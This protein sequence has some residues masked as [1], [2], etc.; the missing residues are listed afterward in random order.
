MLYFP[1]G[2]A[3]A[4]RDVLY[5][6]TLNVLQDAVMC[7]GISIFELRS[8][9]RELELVATRTI[10]RDL[11]AGLE[12]EVGTGIVGRAAAEG[13]GI[14]VENAHDHADFFPQPDRKLHFTTRDLLCCPM[15]YGG[16]V[17]GV[18]ELVNK[19]DEKPFDAAELSSTQA[20]A[21]GVAA[22]W[23]SE[24]SARRRETFYDLTRMARKI[25]D[26][27]GISLFILGEDHRKL[28]LRFSDTTRKTSLEGRRLPIG[29]GVVGAVARERRAIRVDD[30]DSEPHFFAGID[31][32]TS[33]T[34]QSIVAAPIALGEKALGVLELVNGQG[35]EPFTD[36]D[37]D[38]LQTIAAEVA[39]KLRAVA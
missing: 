35:S 29:Q 26:V 3:F 5:G 12:L 15:R 31:A 2:E 28:T 37:R 38:V 9:G 33:F 4:D 7:D 34:T 1:P 23:R 20:L 36:D 14:I 24:L 6:E 17:V 19:V 30:T 11:L 21:D 10:L 22:Y 13:H 16:E 18:I 25:V 39:V 27:E 8:A 32:E